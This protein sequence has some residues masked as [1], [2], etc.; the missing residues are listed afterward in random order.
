MTMMSSKV[1]REGWV[2]S[3]SPPGGCPSFAGTSPRSSRVPRDPCRRRR[4]RACR[5]HRCRTTP[6]ASPRR[7]S[8]TTRA[9]MT[10]RARGRASRA[11]GPAD[12]H[13]G[14][15]ANAARRADPARSPRGTCALGL[16]CGR[17][18]ETR[19]VAVRPLVRRK[20][21]KFSGAVSV[22][23]SGGGDHY[24]GRAD[25]RRRLAREDEIFIGRAREAEG[26]AAPRVT[27]D[28]RCKT[29]STRTCAQTWTS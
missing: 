4:G 14:A 16:G 15:S 22:P 12:A 6:R 25:G 17:S 28:L 26:A 9:T 10:M 7:E 8:W 27:R 11:V 29:N 2:G 23:R 18:D 19:D 3:R 21:K 5:S 13:R 24:A 20:T 1:A